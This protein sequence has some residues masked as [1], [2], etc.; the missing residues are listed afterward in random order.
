LGYKIGSFLGAMT[1]NALNAMNAFADGVREGVK[2]VE[3]LKS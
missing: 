3:I 1:S 2:A